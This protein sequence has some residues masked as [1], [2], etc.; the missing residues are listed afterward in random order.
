MRALVVTGPHAAEVQQVA[1]PV[2]GEGELLV[3]VERVG[4]CGTDVELYTG[5]MAYIPQGFT[6]FPV[7]LGHEWTGTVIGTGSAA[8]ESWLGRRVTGDT[9]LGCGHC[10]YCSAGVHH[11]CPDRFEVGIRDGW[12]GALAEKVL[13]PT[14][15]AHAVPEHV[16]VAAA[17]L[18]EPGGNSLRAVQA[19]ALRRG[20]SV[21][22]L[23]SGTIGL[24]AAQ[25]ALAAGADVHV[26]GVRE[27]SLAL[28][29]TLGVPHTSRLDE[30]DS[31]PDSRFDAV[32]DATSLPTSPALAVRLT[33]PAGRTVFI[34]LSETPSVLDTRELVLKDV[35]AIGILSASPGL[36]GAIESFADG[37][38]VPDPIVSEVIALEDVP[39]RLEGHR[40]AGAKAGPKVHVDPRLRPHSP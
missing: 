22:V 30:L 17:A 36:A 8:D 23:G 3:Q 32:I 14:R 37:S 7:R 11:V 24:L 19:A 39:S 5:E 31:S 4:I 34:G 28:A 35:S 1:D 21:L 18:V 26:A 2:A 12:P 27:D 33:K 9:M 40:G 15:F 25:F 16:S 13:V 10:E 6:H 20:D 29:A 38:V